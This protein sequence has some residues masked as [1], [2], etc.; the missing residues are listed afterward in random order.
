MEKQHTAFC[1]GLVVSREYQFIA[2]TPDGVREFACCGD[3]VVEINCPYCT[4]DLDAELATFLEQGE[5]PT[6]HQYYY[7]VQT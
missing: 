5:L 2:A 1:V 3:G 7:Q 4:K 6:T